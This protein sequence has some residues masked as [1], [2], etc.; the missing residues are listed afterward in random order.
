[1]SKHVQLVLVGLVCF[2]FGCLVAQNLGGLKAEDADR[3]VQVIH[4]KP[5]TFQRTLALIPAQSEKG[6][7]PTWTHALDLKCRKGGQEDFDKAEVFGIEVFKD[8]NNDNLIYI[9][10]TGAIAVVPARGK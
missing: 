7:K 9:S 5:V 3:K 8:E 1:M 4:G 6:K 2:L 10:Q